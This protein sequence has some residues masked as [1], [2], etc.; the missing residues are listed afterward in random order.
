MGL[1]D[2][3]DNNRQASLAVATV[4]RQQIVEGQVVW[5][6][7]REAVEV[8]FKG[9]TVAGVARQV[10]ATVGPVAGRARAVEGLVAAAEEVVVVVV[11]A[12]GGEAEV[13]VEAGGADK[14]VL[15]VGFRVSG[16]S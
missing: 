16:C 5:A 14:Q 7:V 13:E 1:V 3:R 15:S 11:V 8:R 2:E 10:L 12:E 9:S 6:V 4:L